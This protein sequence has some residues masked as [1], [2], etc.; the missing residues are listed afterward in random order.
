VTWRRKSLSRSWVDLAPV[1]T[2]K[3]GVRLDEAGVLA[4]TWAG[5]DRHPRRVFD[6]QAEYDHFVYTLLT[7]EEAGAIQEL[8][9]QVRYRLLVNGVFVCTYIADFVYR[10]GGEE[11]VEDVKGVRTEAYAL[12]YKL[13]KACLGITIRETRVLRPGYRRRRGGRRGAAR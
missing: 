9:C 1:E 5:N 8:R 3:F 13:M 6:S 12:K 11:V 2:S 7:Q 4:R 10:E